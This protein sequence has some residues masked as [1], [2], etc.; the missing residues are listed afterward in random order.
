MRP[1][2]MRHPVVTLVSTLVLTLLALTATGAAPASAGNGVWTSTE[3]YGEMPYNAA[4]LGN[5][6]QGA[7]YTSAF[8]QYDVALQFITWN[9][10]GQSYVEL[11]SATHA[12][13]AA[14][15]YEC[16]RFGLPFKAGLYESAEVTYRWTYFV[17]PG[18][19]DLRYIIDVYDGAT[20]EGA[21]PGAFCP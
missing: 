18:D 21:I 1:A 16:G 10:R 2:A 3:C 19:C 13:F 11:Q 12:Y 9:G 6:G 4:W 17:K 8:A 14:A 20:F 5:P 15:G 7:S